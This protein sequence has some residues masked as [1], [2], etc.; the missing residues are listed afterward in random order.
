MGQGETMNTKRWWPVIG[1][2][3][4]V[5]AASACTA[6]DETDTGPA[7]PPS[8][9]DAF[10]LMN[11]EFYLAPDNR[12]YYL[13]GET[14]PFDLTDRKPPE[15]VKLTDGV[16]YPEGSSG[17]D[18]HMRINPDTDPAFADLDD[19]GEEDIVVVLE[20]T[21]TPDELN[22][23]WVGAF[24]WLWKNGEPQPLEHM[25]AWE[26]NNCNQDYGGFVKHLL[27]GPVRV[28]SYGDQYCD[29]KTPDNNHEYLNART[30]P[31]ET[32]LQVI[33]NMPIA[34]AENG[35]GAVDNCFF[36]G[37]LYEDRADWRITADIQA[38]VYPDKDAPVMTGE[39]LPTPGS[40]LTGDQPAQD[41]TIDGLI[42]RTGPN[43]DREL[44]DG[45]VPVMVTFTDSWYRCGWV[46][47]ADIGDNLELD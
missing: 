19:D 8:A 42:L 23:S 3:A 40:G 22:T 20:W 39:G 33:D 45:W 28:G 5:L 2:T 41:Y 25:G 10:D 16:Y 24:I 4:L 26:W 35:I 14:F 6:T 44:Y 1:L 18:P 27:S 46:N 9:A 36:L 12:P 7:E 17:D 29:A 43:A 30:S 38:R 15:K 34:T 47:W 21:G 13:F 31:N 32:Y 37:N 11:A